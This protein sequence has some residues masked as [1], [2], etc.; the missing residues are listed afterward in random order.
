MTF[1]AMP[2]YFNGGAKPEEYVTYLLSLLMG[3]VWGLIYLF[4]IGFLV[5]LGLAG[6]V[7]T[8]L[9]V[10]VLCAVQCAVHFIPPLGKTPVRNIPIMFGAFSMCFSQGG[11]NVVPITLS[12]IGGL[13]L[14]LICGLG[15][16]FL[17][18][19]GNW[20]LPKTKYTRIYAGIGTGA[21]YLRP[22]SSGQI[23]VKT[24]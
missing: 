5:G 4:C 18:Q 7:A 24:L 20:I 10:G 2:I 15:T 1:V 12:L 11:Q 22:R 13:T 23:G 6:D 9:V 8:A 3:I 16:R 19:E 14:A 21:I 17:S